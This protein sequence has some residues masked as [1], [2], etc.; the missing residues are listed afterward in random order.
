MRER[1]LDVVM[2]LARFLFEEGREDEETIVEELTADGYEPQDIR[3]A[4]DWLEQVAAARGR[5][6]VA[7]PDGDL[8]AARVLTPAEQLKIDAAAYGFLMRMR[9]L[10]LLDGGLLERVLERAMEVETD[11]IG[12]DEIKQISALVLFHR[13]PHEVRGHALDL[14][15]ERRERVYH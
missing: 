10:G 8:S 6:P 4:L 2:L 13:S 12:L 14:G 3:E 9:Q 1:F 5:R 7:R 15:E 11:E